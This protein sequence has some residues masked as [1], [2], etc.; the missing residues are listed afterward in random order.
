MYVPKV[1]SPRNRTNY[2]FWDAATPNPNAQP[3]FPSAGYRLE[4]LIKSYFDLPLPCAVA[5]NPL[6]PTN[7]R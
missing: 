5:F 1:I 3:K 7:I 6:S 2:L 4:E